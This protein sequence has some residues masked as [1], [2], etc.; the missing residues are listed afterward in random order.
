MSVFPLPKGV[1]PKYAVID[2]A[3]SGNN[4]LVAAVSGK[5]IRVLAI[6]MIAAG[7]VVARFESD[8]DG[9]ALTGQMDLTT[10]SGFVLPFNPVGWFQ[11]DAGELLNLELDGAVSVD[12]CLVYAEIG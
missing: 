7:D 10:N 3:T 11:T 4:T 2:D 8:A 6:F 5:Q 1:E 9:T 12:G